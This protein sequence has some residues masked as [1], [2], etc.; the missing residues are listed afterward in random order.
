MIPEY[1]IGDIVTC[2][3]YAGMTP[4]TIKGVITDAFRGSCGG[5]ITV[6]NAHYLHECTIT[7]IETAAG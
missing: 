4:V 2:R 5:W 1:K 3:A 7:K 6:D